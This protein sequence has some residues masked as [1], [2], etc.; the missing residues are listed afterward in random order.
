MATST[1]RLRA[2]AGLIALIGASFTLLAPPAGA[3]TSHCQGHTSE[4]KVEAEDSPATVMVENTTTGQP[5]QVVVTIT[6]TGFTVR[7]TDPSVVLANAEWCVKSSTR[8]NVGTG[9]TG[10]S[11]SFNKRGVRQAISYVV[12]Y[13]VTSQSS[14]PPQQCNQTTTSGGQGVTETLHELG[15]AGPTSFLFEWEAY[16][17]PDQFE[18]FYGGVE[19]YD[20]GLVGDN[21]NEGTGSATVNVPA[22]TSTQV[23]VRVTG[24]EAGT[25][26]DYV[27][28]CPASTTP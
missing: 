3:T 9:T 6:G 18:V 8:T 1:A 17:Q 14:S 11:E 20:T 28:N 24:P 13:S 4:V 27:V 5:I 2:F 16:S 21:I 12:I 22:G 25:V 23:M 7:A 15:V 19:I 10:Q 26:W